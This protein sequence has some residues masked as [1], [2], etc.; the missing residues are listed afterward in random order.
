MTARL[1]ELPITALRGSAGQGAR[2]SQLQKAGYRTVG[3]L[4]TAPSHVLD[5][6]PG[7]GPRT[8]QQVMA[9]A[10]STER[11]V[12]DD[13]PLRFDPDRP[14]PGQTRL[15]ATLAALRS[16]EQ[17]ARSLDQPLRMFVNQTSP[18]IQQAEPAGSRMRMI[19]S[20]S[21]K[22]D[23]ARQAL[24]ELESILA[25]PRVLEAP[26]P[27]PRRRDRGRSQHLSAEPAVAGLPARRGIGQRSPVHRQR[28]SRAGRG[29][30]GGWVHPG[31]TAPEDQ[32]G[33]PR[34]HP[35]DRDPPRI[36]GVRRPVRD[37]P[38]ALDPR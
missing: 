26:P 27:G 8:V 31:G 3:D 1:Q 11:R 20:G 35:V 30:D 12:R 2:L 38:G 29:R 33:P 9:A 25:D 5:A 34:H 19:F 22:R 17:V 6:V 18:L 32:R 23:T 7:V 13:T 4:L 15:L 24:A 37:P 14:D 16:A 28:F 10:R 21:R 36:P